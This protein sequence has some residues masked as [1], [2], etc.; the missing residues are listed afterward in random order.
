MNILIDNVNE[1]YKK[2]LRE[3]IFIVNNYYKEK[4]ENERVKFIYHIFDQDKNTAK[5]IDNYH[6]N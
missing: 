6:W 2:I 4:Y 5:R 1:L 3:D